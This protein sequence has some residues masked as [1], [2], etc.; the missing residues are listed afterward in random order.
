MERLGSR[1]Y[2]VGRKETAPMT[3]HN[4]ETVAV[5]QIEKWTSQEEELANPMTYLDLINKYIYL[6]KSGTGHIII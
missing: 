4:D 2:N 5:N 1:A 3:D 6:H